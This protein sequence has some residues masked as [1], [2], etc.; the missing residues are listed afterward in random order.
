MNSRKTD[1]R[2]KSG[3]VQLEYIPVIMHVHLPAIALSKSDLLV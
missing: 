3:S 2:L 1:G